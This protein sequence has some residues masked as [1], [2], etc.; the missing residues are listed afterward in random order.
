MEIKTMTK[1]NETQ[2][3]S[4]RIY[5]FDSY[6][7]K[8]LVAKEDW[9]EMM[10]T[11]ELYNQYGILV[12]NDHEEDPDDEDGSIC[13]CMEV[14]AYNFFNGSNWQSVVIA[15][16]YD[17]RYEEITNEEEIAKYE[18][19]I[20]SMKFDNSDR[21]GYTVYKAEG[22]EIIESIWQGSWELYTIEESD[23]N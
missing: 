2:K 21:T 4:K 15:A 20:K 7:E 12:D 23:E 9:F 10:P 6:D 18:T 17:L 16:D 19:A 13:N 14:R 5:I 11:C 1:A 3:E 8:V 22:F